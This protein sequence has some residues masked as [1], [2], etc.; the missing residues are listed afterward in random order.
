MTS[1][2]GSVDIAL[3]GKTYIRLS[4]VKASRVR[5]Q[6]GVHSHIFRT[7]LRRHGSSNVV[8]MWLGVIVK[9]FPNIFHIGAVETAPRR[10]SH[11]FGTSGAHCTYAEFVGTFSFSFEPLEPTLRSTSNNSSASVR[12]SLFNS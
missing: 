3:A 12:I 4:A 7:R 1:L 8:I 9:D 2:N 6:L 5:S 11:G 10:G